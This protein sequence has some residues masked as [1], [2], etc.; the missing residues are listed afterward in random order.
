M[1]HA[2]AMHLQ[3]IFDPSVLTFNI[4]WHCVLLKLLWSAYLSDVDTY[5]CVICLLYYK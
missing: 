5:E 1:S 2:N 3:S 4:L